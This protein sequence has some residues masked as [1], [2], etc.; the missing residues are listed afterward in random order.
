[1]SVGDIAP[2][3]SI[4]YYPVHMYR[5]EVIGSVVVVNKKITRSQ[6]LGTLTTCKCNEFVKSVE[7]WPHCTSNGVAQPIP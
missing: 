5:G 3:S 7:N 6:H 4:Y 2:E 1:M